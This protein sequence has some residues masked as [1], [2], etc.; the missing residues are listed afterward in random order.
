[1]PLRGKD[2]GAEA[3]SPTGR[4]GPGGDLSGSPGPRRTSNAAGN[5]DS[6][7]ADGAAVHSKWDGTGCEVMAI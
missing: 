1:M 4:G 6:G 3:E 7:M 2:G 5:K